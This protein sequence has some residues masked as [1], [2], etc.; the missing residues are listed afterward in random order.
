MRLTLPDESIVTLVSGYELMDDRHPSE[1]G[2]VYSTPTV[3]RMLS[4]LTPLID[5]EAGRRRGD[6]VSWTPT[7]GRQS[8][9][10]S[11]VTLVSG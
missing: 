2:L 7:L 8:L 3:N 4:D 9:D 10:E 5:S 1:K 6:P 11:V